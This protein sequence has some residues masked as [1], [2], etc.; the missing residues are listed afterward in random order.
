MIKSTPVVTLRLSIRELL[1]LTLVGL[2]LLTLFIMN[3]FTSVSYGTVSLSILNSSQATANHS[4]VPQRN[5]ARM[6]AELPAC[7]AHGRANT[8]LMLFMGHSGSTAIM[9]SLQ[10]HSQTS[11]HGFEPVD[12]GEFR[13]GTTQENA[14]KALEYTSHFFHNASK[15]GLT[16]GFKI[17]PLHISKNP[18][19][20]AKLIR[21]YNTRIIWSY[22]SNMLK[23][24]IGDYGIYLGD[25]SAFEGIEIKPNQT[26]PDRSNRSIHIDSIERLHRFMKSRVAGDKQVAAA[27]KAVSKDHCVL[28][29]SY[30]SFLKDP[31]LTVLRVQRF[32]GLDDSEIHQSTRAKANPDTICDLVQNWEQLCEA[33]FGCV[34]WRWMLDDFEN[35]CSCSA[36]RPSR[37]GTKFCSIK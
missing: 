32:L 18:E 20:F 3:D 37:F 4:D 25:R 23:Q 2:L 17:R 21:R 27:L 34:Q 16:S 6:L 7:A 33:F 24:A 13:A 31:S 8:F 35:G 11:I 36:L 14:K 15:H 19:G 29:V 26:A 1:A 5:R 22:R 10:Q 28:P 12:H 9:T 30:E